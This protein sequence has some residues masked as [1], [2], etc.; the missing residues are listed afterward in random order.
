MSA[1]YNDHLF[2]FGLIRIDSV[3]LGEAKWNETIQWE[4][5]LES[6]LFPAAQLH[7]W[8]ICCGEELNRSQMLTG[9]AFQ[10]GETKTWSARGQRVR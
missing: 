6:H 2:R 4:S 8:T 10:S 1:T 5:V 3:I 7:K 9:W